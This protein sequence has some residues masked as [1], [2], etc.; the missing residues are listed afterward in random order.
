[1]KTKEKKHLLLQTC[2]KEWMLRKCEKMGRS[3]TERTA[4]L[5]SQLDTECEKFLD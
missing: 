3:P 1:M 4:N 5:H 2:G